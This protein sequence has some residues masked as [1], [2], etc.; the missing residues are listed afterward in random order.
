MGDRIME[1]ID[2]SKVLDL[3]LSYHWYDEIASGRKKEEYRQIKPFYCQRIGDFCKYKQY[4][5]SCTM[6]GIDPVPHCARAEA[7]DELCASHS[8]VYAK[9][10]THVRFHRG[11]GSPIIMLVEC[12]GISI[13]K[14]NPEWGAPI[15]EEVFIIKLGKIIYN[16]NE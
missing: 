9:Q 13:G 4:G 2:Y 10:Y 16:Y 5:S 7:H 14:G 6:F 12:K 11:Q 3:S 8:H 1:D 15:D